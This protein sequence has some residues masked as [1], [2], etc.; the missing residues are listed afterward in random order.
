MIYEFA[1]ALTEYGYLFIKVGEAAD[2]FVPELGITTLEEYY[3][4]L[5]EIKRDDEG[6][7]TI[8]TKLPLDEAYFEINA[9]TR[10]ITIPS[11]FKKNGIGVQGD[12]LAE[13]VYFMIDRY[14]DAMDLNN[15]EIFIEWETPKG[16]SGTVTKSVSETYL[17]IIDDELYP[18]KLIFG[19]AI[20]DAITKDSGNLKFAVR[21]VQWADSE[22]GKKKLVYSF[23]TLTA[24]VS[25][26]P[27]LGLNL[28]EDTYEIDNANDRLL[29]RIEPGEVVGGAQAMVPYYL[30][31]IKI[32]ADGYDIGPNHSEGTYTL[33][34]VATADDTG[35]VSYVWKRADLNENNISNDAWIEIADSN[36]VK[37]FELT[38]EEL[39]TFDYKLPTTHTYYISNDE[40]ASYQPLD[41]GKYNLKETEE[42]NITG[43]IP[44]VY[45]Q[46]G[47]LI[48]EEYG[49][50]RAEARNR[51]FNSLTKKN[52]E[53]ATFKRPDAIK[54]L[55][56]D[57]TSD[58]HILNTDS[59]K[60]TPKFEEAVG[61]LVYQW[62]RA[63][64]IPLLSEKVI[65]D[66][67]PKNTQVAYSE[68]TVRIMCPADT[69]FEH[70]NVGATGNKNLY[71][72][73]QKLYAPENAVKYAQGETG[74]H[75]LETM[76][77][78][79]DIK[80]IKDVSD[81]YGEDENGLYRLRWLPVAYYD[82]SNGLWTYYAKNAT[83]LGG[84]KYEIAWYDANGE[85][86]ERT[87]MKIELA[88][89]NTFGDLNN[90]VAIDTEE[91]KE[92]D[93]IATEAGLYQ[94]KVT[95][96]R[97]RASIDNKSIEYR[98]TAEPVTP[99]WSVGVY[100]SSEQIFISNLLAGKQALTVE[101]EDTQADEFYIVWKLYRQDRDEEDLPIY[102]QKVT[103]DI[104]TH[105]FN[106][107]NE[108]FKAVYEDAN[109]NIEGLYYAQIA[110]KL[111]GVMS[112]YS[113]VPATNVMFTVIG[114]QN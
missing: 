90:Y 35:A 26:A 98:V 13:V 84:W 67:M 103:G 106:P 107:T 41:K 31:D 42:F 104:R 9:N 74:L 71:Y 55:N 52:S 4:W 111:N 8:F 44:T 88:N 82:P 49:Q 69:K 34:V 15:T 68:D 32:L 101:W 28:E 109:E 75:P 19:W 76:P 66:Y 112:G 113:E 87:L 102:T 114:S 54:M 81:E 50:Y 45:E 99:D 36:K 72:I 110:T 3:N 47:Y 80:G 64:E 89:E 24:Q 38:D 48:V 7:P 63:D 14:F 79:G 96:I 58:K 61:D 43:I 59:A 46:R 11:E 21:F 22:S 60:L 51:I 85:E 37:M 94:L 25:I 1:E 17:K 83:A 39:I 20:S 105:S 57:Q 73:A 23:N 108:M 27:N 100:D 53:V 40:G 10:A 97:N 30:T 33:Q 95:R 62:Y 6:N 65:F 78:L 56:A 70:Q 12:D 5:P 29:E 91:A 86:I 77:V 93:Y 18:G 16:K 92:L 2:G